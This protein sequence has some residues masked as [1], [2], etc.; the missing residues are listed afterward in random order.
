[1]FL[2]EF[3]FFIKVIYTMKVTTKVLHVTV[4]LLSHYV[5][6]NSEVNKIK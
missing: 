1:M 6:C 4:M 5:V 2:K 3:Y